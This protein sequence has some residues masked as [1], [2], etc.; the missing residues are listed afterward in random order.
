MPI[1]S[2]RPLIA[3]S[4]AV[5]TAVALAACG[6]SSGS[7]PGTD[8]GPATA[9]VGGLAPVSHGAAQV[10]VKLTDSSGDKCTLNHKQAKAGPVT[11]AITN[12]S[13]T[14]ITE[15]E[16]QQSL[17]IVGE[18]ENLAPGLPT[19]SFT[20]TLDGGHYTVYCPGANPENQTF[21]VSGQAAASQGGDAAQLL[22]SGTKSYA[23][24]VLSQAQAMQ[25]AVDQLDHAVDTGNMIAARKDYVLAR[26]FYEKIE[27]DVDGFILPGFKAD[28]NHGNLDYLIDMR[29]SNLDPK[30]G[31][32]GFH[33][34]ERDLYQRDAITAQTKGYANMLKTH[35]NELVHV[36]KGLTYKP[37]DLGNGAADL[38]EE[39][40]STKVTGEEEDFS[41]IDLV[42]M[43]ANI[44]GAQQAFAD[45]QPGLEKIDPTLTKT[46]ADEFTQ[47]RNALNVYR[48]ANAPG[49][50]IPWT[51]TNRRKDA[52]GLSQTV[53]ALQQ[54]LQQIAEKVA[55]AE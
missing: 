23:S 22:A 27:S 25:S 36:V 42:D 14:A 24:W 30:V 4:A 40:Q 34:V 31:W 52:K 16:L 15:V 5:L 28:D 45:L 10:S 46:V 53:L 44:E 9:S 49:G 39:V 6:S 29:A 19:S 33:A 7:G 13:S 21:T 43:S 54:P 11:F 3:A 17:R 47:V 51:P 18:R 1:H 38:L 2:L 35:V 12:V 32:T 48:D 20:V 26:P 50:Y 37:E 55:T 8:P 41:H